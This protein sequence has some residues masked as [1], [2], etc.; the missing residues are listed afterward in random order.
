LVVWDPASSALKIVQERVRPA[1][2]LRWRGGSNEIIYFEESGGLVS[3]TPDSPVVTTLLHRNY[4]IVQ[5]KISE[6]GGRV[7]WVDPAGLLRGMSPGESEPVYVSLP[8][9]VI[10]FA[11]E[12]EDAL[13]AIAAAIPRRLPMRFHADYTLWRIPVTTWKGLQ[14]PYDPL[15]FAEAAGSMDIHKLP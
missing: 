12:G 15:I 13:V 8:G 6:E 1:G 10:D 11:W 4:P 5:A 3:V 7:A 9:E 2:N 14:L